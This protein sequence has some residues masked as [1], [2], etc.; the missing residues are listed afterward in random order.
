MFVKPN[1]SDVTLHN[2]D[3]V[4]IREI[5]PIDN[6][7]LKAILGN[8]SLD[9][10]TLSNC[11][12]AY[13][14]VGYAQVQEDKTLKVMKIEPVKT[15]EDLINR[16]AFPLKDWVLIVKAVTELNEPNEQLLGK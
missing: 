3:V 4:K 11:L 16:M 14:I 10:E 15:Y 6:V 8:E 1:T 5:M 13:C 7:R 9:E 2:G 12:F